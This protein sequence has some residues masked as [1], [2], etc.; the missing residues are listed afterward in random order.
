M[1]SKIWQE[2]RSL[3]PVELEAKLRDSEEKLF[4]LE[5]RHASTPLKNALEI[6]KLRRDVA[7]FKTLLREKAQASS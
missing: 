2:I 7:R 5:F 6:R 4:R 3:S 1:K